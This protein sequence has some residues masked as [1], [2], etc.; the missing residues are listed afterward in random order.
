MQSRLV[1][2]ITPA[3]QLP[4]IYEP[5]KY[6]FNGLIEAGFAKAGVDGI[7]YLLESKT[8]WTTYEKSFITLEI[9][10]RGSD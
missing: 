3:E 6:G 10:A 5:Q 2:P 9:D 1:S 8:D 7:F 4:N